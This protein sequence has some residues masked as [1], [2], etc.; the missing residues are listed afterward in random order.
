V[1]A[2]PGATTDTV[3]AD[4]LPELVTWVNTGVA[5]GFGVVIVITLIEMGKQ[6]YR[7]RTIGRLEEPPVVSSAER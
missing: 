4:K 1:V 3:P 7:L 5:I 2:T 6:Y